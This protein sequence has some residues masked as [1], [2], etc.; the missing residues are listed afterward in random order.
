MAIISDD[1]PDDDLSSVEETEL[2]PFPLVAVVSL[3][4]GCRRDS[5]RRKPPTPFRLDFSLER[6]DTYMVAEYHSDRSLRATVALRTE[7]EGEMDDA[8]QA[9]LYVPVG[10]SPEWEL[11]FDE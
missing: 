8:V 3:V 5:E 4:D 10:S 11:S 1:I 6:I 9:L 7:G 2:V